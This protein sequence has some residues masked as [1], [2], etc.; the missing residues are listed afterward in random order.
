MSTVKRCSQLFEMRN[1]RDIPYEKANSNEIDINRVAF[2]LIAIL[3]RAPLL[4]LQP[5]L[6][7]SLLIK[8][9]NKSISSW[10]KRK[11]KLFYFHYIESKMTFNHKTSCLDNGTRGRGNTRPE[12]STFL[13]NRTSDGGT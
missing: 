7:P 1:P 13:S 2:F 12:I 10:E 8:Q 3:S 5:H 6:S 9:K 4:R 11:K